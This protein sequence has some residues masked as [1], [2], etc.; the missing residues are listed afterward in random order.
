MVRT[1]QWVCFTCKNREG[2]LDTWAIVNGM[3]PPQEAC[4]L[5][6]Y[7][8]FCSV[9]LVDQNEGTIYSDLTGRFPVQS[10]TGM[11]YICVAHIYSKSV[12][13]LWSMPNR[14]YASMVKVFKEIYETLKER[15]WHP[16]LHVL[17][18]KCLKAV[19]KYIISERV[20]IQIAKPHNHWVNADKPAAKCAKYHKYNYRPY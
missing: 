5:R 14:T 13:L 6:D 9:V 15:Q 7:E 16:K 18:N 1:C 19:K 17:Y 20:N 10:Y 2:I 3:N 11:Q 8:V 12:L 4:N